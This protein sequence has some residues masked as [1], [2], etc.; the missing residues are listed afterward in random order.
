[1]CDIPVFKRPFHK[2]RRAVSRDRSAEQPAAEKSSW[3]TS[4]SSAS[5]AAATAG[6]SNTLE[7]P[8]QRGREDSPTLVTSGP[9][10]ERKIDNE[11]H[12]DPEEKTAR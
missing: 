5:V 12:L 3:P 8:G 2:L 6:E 7:V 11:A 10:V 4:A 1:M 9:V